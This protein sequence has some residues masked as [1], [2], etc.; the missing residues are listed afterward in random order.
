MANLTSLIPPTSVPG[1]APD[2]PLDVPEILVQV[3]TYLSP[4]DVHRC[5]FVNK[6]FRA[7]FARIFWRSV[8]LGPDQDTPYATLNAVRANAHLIQSLGI[9][10]ESTHFCAPYLRLDFP[11]LTEL[12]IEMS[13]CPYP[14]SKKSPLGTKL[15]AFLCRHSTRIQA[16][17]VAHRTFKDNSSVFW[18][19]IARLAALST[20]ELVN[21]SLVG[22]VLGDTLLKMFS[23]LQSLRLDSV[24]LLEL[25][26]TFQD[27]DR[28]TLRKIECQNCFFDAES[29]QSLCHLMKI[30][31]DLRVLIWGDWIMIEKK[32]QRQGTTFEPILG[33]IGSELPWNNLD[34]LDVHN[35]AGDTMVNTFKAFPRGVPNVMLTEATMNEEGHVTLLQNFASNLTTIV[36]EFCEGLKSSMIQDVLCSCNNLLSVTTDVSLMCSSVMRSS[37]PWACSKLQ[38]WAISVVIDEEGE[39]QEDDDD[40]L[41]DHYRCIFEKLSQLRQLRVL[42]VGSLRGF[43]DKRVPFLTFRESAGV[44]SLSTLQRM[45]V[46]CAT[47]TGQVLSRGDWEWLIQTFRGLKRVVGFCTAEDEMAEWQD[48]LDRRAIIH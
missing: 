10:W 39:R 42:N 41:E 33:I 2:N 26:T 3:S 7:V 28:S 1:L 4:R 12:R 14:F 43:L 46:L 30:S 25:W 9:V 47:G 27:N 35:I 19:S 29:L 34:R 20:V 24:H 17:L 31:A 32:K 11:V 16:L 22:N 48:A 8:R 40:R 13:D 44:R 18:K 37:K 5:L 6:S 23:T 36:F 45:Q 21:L 15:Y 38:K